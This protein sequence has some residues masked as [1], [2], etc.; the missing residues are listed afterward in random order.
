[1]PRGVALFGYGCSFAMMM[2]LEELLF[3]RNLI[4]SRDSTQHAEPILCREAQYK[5]GTA[6]PV[7]DAAS[8]CQF[9]RLQL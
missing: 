8:P 7:P 4:R 1:M 5:V 9:F 6:W 3:T 2:C